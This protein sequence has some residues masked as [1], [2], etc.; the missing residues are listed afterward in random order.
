[1]V[2]DWIKLSEALRETKGNVFI[3]YEDV[4]ESRLFRFTAKRGSYEKRFYAVYTSFEEITLY[5]QNE[6]CSM[7]SGKFV[8]PYNK[9]KEWYLTPDAIYIYLTW[10]GARK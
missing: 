3:C 1:M 2:R 9:F 6:Y 4:E 5:W 8:I 7:E 10:K